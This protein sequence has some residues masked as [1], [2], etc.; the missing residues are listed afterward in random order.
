MKSSIFVQALFRCPF[1]NDVLEDLVML[2]QKVIKISRCRIDSTRISEL[3]QSAESSNGIEEGIAG[4]RFRLG[5]L[6]NTYKLYEKQ[7]KKISNDHIIDRINKSFSYMV[8]DSKKSMAIV[9]F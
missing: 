6:L 3:K 9:I 7:H 2:S 1:P 8:N 5:L 4:A